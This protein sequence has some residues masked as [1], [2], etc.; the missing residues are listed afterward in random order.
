MIESKNPTC[1]VL[2]LIFELIT[3][4]LKIDPSNIYALHSSI[5]SIV[6]DLLSLYNKANS[7][8]PTPLSNIF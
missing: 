3:I 4:I 5:A 6:A 8:N 2:L 7:P 1:T